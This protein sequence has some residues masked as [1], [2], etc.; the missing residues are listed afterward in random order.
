M[1]PT[2]I[3]LDGWPKHIRW[4]ECSTSEDFFNTAPRRVAGVAVPYTDEFRDFLVA[5]F[6]REGGR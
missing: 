4:D 3:G 6:L 1:S 5:R 2:I